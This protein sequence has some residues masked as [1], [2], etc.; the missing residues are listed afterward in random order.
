M[1]YSLNLSNFSSEQIA[2]GYS[3]AHETLIALHVFYDC[4]HHPLHIP[5]V[6]NAR[7][8]ISPALKEEIEN[9]SLFYKRPIVSFWELSED[10]TFRS[11]DSDLMEMAEQP[12]ETYWQKIIETL[13]DKNRNEIHWDQKLHNELIE[14]GDRRYP[15]S[16]EVILELLETP[17]KSRRRFLQML[18]GFWNACLK[19]EWPL[20]EELF[21]KDISYRGKIL[22][23][24]G[25]FPLLTGLSD[26]IDV[27]PEEK[28]AVVRRISKGE[29]DL[30]DKDMLFLAPTYFAWPHVFMSLQHPVGINYS[31]RNH[32]LEAA[33]PM[34]P[35]D[36]LKFFRALG[37]FTRLQ[38]VKYLAQK[39]RSTRELA[40]LIGVTEG[41]V[42]KHLKQLENAGLIASKRE[43]YY[44][45]YRLLEKPFHDFPLG[46]SKFIE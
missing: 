41:A 20:I 40:L 27:Y 21:L 33:K 29:I 10:S 39:P 37:D 35:E 19:E 12:I 17:E 28:R 15:E 1:S 22:L 5:W 38:I 46:L 7:K 45:F 36:L 2:F 34:P 13:M 3:A 18:E 16:K 6:I 31:I 30:G 23:D 25:P 44:V 42:S 43:S 26:T 24:E 4:K 9:F 14:L 11:F 32:Q 8:K